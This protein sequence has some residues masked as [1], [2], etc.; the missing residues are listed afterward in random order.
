M[1]Y[2]FTILVAILTMHED[3][4]VI[5]GTTKRDDSDWRCFLI[6]ELLTSYEMLAIDMI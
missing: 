3:D 5:T 4:D 6:K 2:T 1:L